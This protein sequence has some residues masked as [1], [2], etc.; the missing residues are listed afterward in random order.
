[1]K[2]FIRN[3]IILGSLLIQP[4][5]AQEEG[6]T[7]NFADTIFILAAHT[8]FHV[9][10]ALAHE[11]GHILAAQLFMRCGASLVQ[12]PV[13]HTAN[14]PYAHEP[15]EAAVDY[16]PNVPQ[17]ALKTPTAITFLGEYPEFQSCW[18][19]A[20]VHLAGPLSGIAA[21]YIALKTTNIIQELNK[22]ENL[23]I[24]IKN[25][26]KKPVFNE[27]QPS[28]IRGLAFTHMLLNTFSL[29]PVSSYRFDSEGEK[30][31]QCFFKK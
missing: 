18:V 16:A 30:I 19:N 31:R 9:S 1:M 10:L 26:F 14:A 8:A 12:D 25:G 3:S 21:S 23:K 24:A 11:L 28:G 29:I 17:T 20:L 5:Q 6:M 13:H 7:L 2:N 22:K 27:D 4:L 15:S